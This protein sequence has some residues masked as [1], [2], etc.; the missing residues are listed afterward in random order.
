MLINR[1]GSY[2]PVGATSV[3]LTPNVVLGLRRANSA[4]VSARPRRLIPS[5]ALASG[6]P[7]RVRLPGMPCVVPVAFPLTYGSAIAQLPVR[8]PSRNVCVKLKPIVPIEACTSLSG[9]DG[10]SDTL[11]FELE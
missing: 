2:V 4:G 6:K 10:S 5:R 11:P 1:A 8:R 7:S 9:S 3:A